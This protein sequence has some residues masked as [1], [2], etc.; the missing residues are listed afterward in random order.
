MKKV[1]LSTFALLAT[2]AANAGSLV[3]T[4]PEVIAIEEPARMGGSGAWIIPLIIVSVLLLTLTGDDDEAEPNGM[5]P[6][7]VTY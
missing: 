2:S 7:G 5:Q 4:A 3:Y 6:N 1:L